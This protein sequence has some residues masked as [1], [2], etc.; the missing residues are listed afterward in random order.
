MVSE[1]LLEF[2]G[3]GLAIAAVFGSLALARKH[4]PASKPISSK[5]FFE[6]D[7]RFRGSV[8]RIAYAVMIAIGIGVVFGTHFLLEFSNRFLAIRGSSQAI[9]LLPQ[10]AIW[11]FFPGFAALTLS[12]EFMLRLWGI[13]NHKDAELFSLWTNQRAGFDSRKTLLCLALLL[14]I[15]I[16]ILTFLAVPMHATLDQQEIQD[17]GYAFAPCKVYRYS[18]ARRLTAI[19]GFRTKDGK[20]TL[21]AGILVDFVDGQRWSSADW[22]DFSKTLNHQLADFLVDHTGLPLQQGEAERDIAP[23]KPATD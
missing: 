17:C 23:L 14:A 7:Q 18:D 9:H 6:L 8:N 4:F 1:E 20:L 2:F 13:R 11:W 21:R 3:R 22:G 19:R 10:S 15:P 5:Q 16:G 12:W